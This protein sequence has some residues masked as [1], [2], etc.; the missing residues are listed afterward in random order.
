MTGF[1]KALL[2]LAAYISSWCQI[3]TELYS[4]SLD[5]LNIL[6]VSPY[7]FYFQ[8]TAFDA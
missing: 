3:Q 8:N 4:P 2:L 1:M 7:D 6:C 5:Y